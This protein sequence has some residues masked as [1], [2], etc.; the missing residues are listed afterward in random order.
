MSCHS[1]MS[2]SMLVAVSVDYLCPTNRSFHFLTYPHLWIP[3]THPP[4]LVDSCSETHPHLWTAVLRL[5]SALLL[6]LKSFY[7]LSSFW[8]I[9][10]KGS[11]SICWF[12]KTKSLSFDFAK[13]KLLNQILGCKT[14]SAEKQRKCPTDLTPQPTSQKERTRFLLQMS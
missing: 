6:H 3:E 8:N 10:D 12:L 11:W 7:M 13:W 1:F 4:T 9:T 14:S 2:S 5:A